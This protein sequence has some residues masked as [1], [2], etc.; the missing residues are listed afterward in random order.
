MISMKQIVH[1]RILILLALM[2]VGSVVHSQ[3]F[4]FG[5]QANPGLV[6]VKPDN[7]ELQGDGV[8]FTFDFGIVFDYIFGNE[9]RY[10]FNTGLNILVT[11]AKLQGVTDDDGTTLMSNVTARINYLEVPLA[12][13]L[14]SNEVGYFN[15]YGQL[16]ITPAFAI[17][18]RAD[19]T[20]ET[21]PND[22]GV[23]VVEEKDNVKFKDVPFY[24][25]TIEKV[26][27]FNLGLHTEAGLE[28]NITENTILVAGIYFNTGF[29]DMFKDH[30]NERIVSRNLG[31]RLGILF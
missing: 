9:D 27:P 19:Y 23:I 1:F 31:F 16:G 21:N 11:G 28:Y 8:R 14:R 18:S 25:N 24:P 6:W 15:F 10:A 7:T 17:R 22:D 2:M 26:K 13:K 5:I 29:M 30:D 4:R 3:D 12:I 20:I